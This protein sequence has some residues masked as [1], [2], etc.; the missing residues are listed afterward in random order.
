M[1]SSGTPS[2]GCHAW[3]I[4]PLSV[5]AHS[6]TPRK[7]VDSWSLTSPTK[8]ASP[9]MTSAH[10]SPDSWHR[11]T[12][13]INSTIV[14][15]WTYNSTKPTSQWQLSY[16]R[17]SRRVDFANCKKFNCLRVSS[18]ASFVSAIVAMEITWSRKPKLLLRPKL[19][20]S[21]PSTSSKTRKPT[22][23]WRHWITI[24]AKLPPCFGSPTQ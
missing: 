17:S 16:H 18:M 1:A 13:K 23:T 24:S 8:S 2:H 5:A 19:Q 9:K 20:H 3:T 12:S 14:Q 21:P 10:S 22:S 15:S 7:C 6:R 4:P 11:T